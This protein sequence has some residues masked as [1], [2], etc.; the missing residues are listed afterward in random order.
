MA[1]ELRAVIEVHAQDGQRQAVHGSV[2]GADDVL[3][4]VV[5]D[6]AGQGP[7][8]EH[9]GHV[10]GADELSFEGRTA[11]GDGVDLEEPRGLLDLVAGLADL[12][13]AAQ[14]RA[15]LGRRPAPQLVRWTVP[16]RGSGRWSLRS[17]SPARF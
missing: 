1:D 10:Q 8:R 15:G 7:P 6:R 9:I 16:G 5:A 2:Q 17:W 14:Q 4:G 12:D 13:G 11:V 3:L